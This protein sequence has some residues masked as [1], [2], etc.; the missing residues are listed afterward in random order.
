VKFGALAAAFAFAASSLS[1]ASASAQQT[2]RVFV[3]AVD[4]PSGVRPDSSEYR[5]GLH[6]ELGPTGRV[7]SCRIVE[8]SRQPALD[9]ESCRI[10]LARVL[11]RPQAGR[12]EGSLVFVWLGDASAGSIRTP[13]EPLDYDLVGRISYLDYPA[14]ARRRSGT[15]A[16]AVRVSPFGRPI[17]C[18]ITQSSGVPALDQRTCNIVMTRGMYIPSTDGSRPVAGVA[19]GR[20]RWV[21]P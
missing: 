19:H 14:E 5:V 13:G 21:A 18:T 12:M 16:Y 10:A 4:Y 9:A 6:Y 20:I 3:P 15:T 1:G 8:P 11:I 2:V 7:A 17:D